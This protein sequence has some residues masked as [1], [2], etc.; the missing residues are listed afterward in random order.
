MYLPVQHYQNKYKKVCIKILIHTS[1]F[2][3]STNMTLYAEN[4]ICYTNDTTNKKG[5]VS[6]L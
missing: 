3:I 6:Y 2:F 4:K 5:L 1:L